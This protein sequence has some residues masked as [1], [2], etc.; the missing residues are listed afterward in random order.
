M[1]AIKAYAEATPYG[2]GQRITSDGEILYSLPEGSNGQWVDA[3]QGAVD[4]VEWYD[5]I[6]KKW[7]FSQEHNFSAM[8]ELIN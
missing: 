5:V 6:Y 2:P 4:D 1:E 7:T 8:V 3:Y